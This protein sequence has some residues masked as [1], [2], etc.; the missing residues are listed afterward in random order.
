MAPLDGRDLSYDVARCGQC[1]FHYASDLPSPAVYAAYY[2]ELS[3][4]DQEGIG[5]IPEPLRERASQAL[6][7]CRPHLAGD[8]RIIDIGCGA[9]A[10]LHAFREAGFRRLHGIDPAPGGAQARL[11]H[12]GGENILAGNLR[13]AH[14]LPLADADLVCLTGIAEHLPELREDMAWLCDQLGAGPR[15]LIEVPSADHFPTGEMPYEPFGEF[16]LE[17]LQYFDANALTRLMADFGFHP[18]ALAVPLL[19]DGRAGSL[20]GLFA[21]GSGTT[22]PTAAATGRRMEDYLAVSERDMRRVIDRIAAHGGPF[23][24]HGAGSHTARLLPRLATAGLADRIAGL[25]DN[26]RNLQGRKLGDYPILPAATL[27]TLPATAVLVSSF[28]AQEAIAASLPAT[29]PALL[30][31]DKR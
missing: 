23:V 14:R 4:Y 11:G 22:H 31:Y 19:A 24:I 28:A 2:R 20:F 13:D 16:S 5:S 15:I 17:H 10:L 27:A 1:G 6:A 29:S 21:R 26:N 12:D 9:G 30:L 3:K 25:V 7:L 8:A 18:L